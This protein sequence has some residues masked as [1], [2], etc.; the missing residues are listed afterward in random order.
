MAGR[1]VLGGAGD[2]YAGPLPGA[3]EAMRAALELAVE[4][5]G[6]GTFDWDLGSGELSFDDRLLA[7]FGYDKESFE[8]RAGLL[9][10]LAHPADRDRVAELYRRA[11]AECGEYELEHRVVLPDG[12]TRWVASRGRAICDGTGRA[13]RLL[14]AFYE[15]TARREG[16]AQ[17]ARA[18]DAI[19]TAFFALGADWC[20]SYV[21]REAE[22]LL[23]RG[24]E[25]LIGANVWELFPAAVGS[26]FEDNYRR[27]LASGQEVAF[28]AY[29]PSP[30]NSWYEVRAVPGPEG[31]AVYFSDISGRREAQDMAER[32]VQRAALLS[33]VSEALSAV[34]NRDLAARRLAQRLVPTL[35]D[36]CVV[37]LVEDEGVPARRRLRA[38]GSWHAEPGRRALVERYVR[39]HL[40]AADDD[41]LVRVV[42]R[43]EARFLAAGAMKEL[44]RASRPGPHLDLLEQLAPSSV[45]VLPLAGPEAAV[46]MLALCNGEARGTFS[47]SDVAAARDV[48]AR[49]GLVLDRARLYRR[50]REV[51]QGLQR[52]LLSPPPERDDFE[53]EVRYSPA[54]EAIQVGGDWY[55]AF[56]QAD[57]GLVLVIGDV[58]GHDLQAAAAMGQVRTL[59][60]G[61]GAVGTDGPAEIL[62]KVDRVMGTLCL[63]TTATAVVARV[64]PA[65][66]EGAAMLCW[67]NAG[68]PPPML[69]RADGTVVTL[70]D[71]AVGPLLGV[72]PTAERSQRHVHLGPSDVVVFYTDGLVERRGQSI[73]VGLEEMARALSGLAGRS[74]EE[75]CDGLLGQLLPEVPEDDVAL[76]V[77]R[78]HPVPLARPG[79]AAAS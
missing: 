55:D 40:A 27:A 66:P 10:C 15:T 50:Q 8:G 57:G 51:A 68:H 12:V 3:D 45:L 24:R 6:V 11:I 14:G 63:D 58:M 64:V 13:V 62:A 72:E 74:L 73:E 60:R 9:E 2:R 22:R 23:G 71:E 76:V 28:D 79:Q 21:N 65:L 44:R 70:D 53:V 34:T 26:A 48:A 17:V 56:S 35:A 36:W 7:L 43:G 25:E 5:A 16:E 32:A 18:M 42:D 67:S 39:A 75:L 61:L 4:V 33:D 59:V 1:G 46:G 29:Y 30:L 41:G 54:A 78:S 49:A 47:A 37:A 31:L 19:G 52:S 69:L 20:F 38:A 77:V